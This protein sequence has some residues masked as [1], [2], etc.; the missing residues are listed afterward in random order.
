M[1]VLLIGR[2][3]FCLWLTNQKQ[4]WLVMS[5]QYEISDIVSQR[6]FLGK[7]WCTAKYQLFTQAMCTSFSSLFLKG[8][9]KENWI[10]PLPGK[11]HAQDIPKF[12]LSPLNN[13][14]KRKF[15][16]KLSRRHVTAG[17][18]TS[19]FPRCFIRSMYMGPWHW[20]A[21]GRHEISSSFVQVSQVFL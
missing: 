3:K 20:R 11:I 21:Q 16:I 12:P 18:L 10:S 5:C 7:W 14:K 13:H 19:K 9:H 1:V 2:S 15:W 6:S 4:I 8:F 17:I